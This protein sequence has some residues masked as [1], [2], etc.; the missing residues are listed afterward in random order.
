MM[1]SEVF[2]SNEKKLKGYLRGYVRDKHTVEDIA[3]DSWLKLSAAIDAGRVNNVDHAERLIYTIARTL[4]V[5]YLKKKKPELRD[6]HAPRAPTGAIIELMDTEDFNVHEALVLV[7]EVNKMPKD[8]RKIFEMLCR[9]A[10]AAN[11]GAV[12]GISGNAV[13]MRWVRYCNDVRA[14]HESRHESRLEPLEVQVS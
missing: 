13:N 12:L 14:R 9:G 1:L 8:T 11:I 4:A 3:Q 10:S 5:N 2:T 7:E 6:D